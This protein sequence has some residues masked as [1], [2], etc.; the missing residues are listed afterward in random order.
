[1]TIDDVYV[2][3]APGSEA[4]RALDPKEL[5]LLVVDGCQSEEDCRRVIVQLTHRLAD[6]AAARG[7]GSQPALFDT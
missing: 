6:L 7:A 5:A 2:R 1:M 4:L 3:V